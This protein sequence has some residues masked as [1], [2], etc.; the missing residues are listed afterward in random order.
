[1]RGSMDL[2]SARKNAKKKFV[3]PLA[4]P[5]SELG[6]AS[7]IPT[8][9]VHAQPSSITIDSDLTLAVT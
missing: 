1:M 2:V 3:K 6:S 5:V 8:L 4:E 7:V 9:P